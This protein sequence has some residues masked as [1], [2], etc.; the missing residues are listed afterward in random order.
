VDIQVLATPAVLSLVAAAAATVAALSTA[1]YTL[2]IMPLLRRSTQSIELGQRAVFL[3]ALANEAQLYFATT[4]RNPDGTL[5]LG[6][7]Q[8]APREEIWSYIMKIR[9]IRGE[10]EDGRPCTARRRQQPT[11]TGQAA[12]G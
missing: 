2:V 9:S 4:E 7:E 10:L 12:A 1:V 5:R 11:Q 3:K 8:A 6:V